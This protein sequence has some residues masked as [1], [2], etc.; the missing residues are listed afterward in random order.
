MA[1]LYFQVAYDAM[2]TYFHKTLFSFLSGL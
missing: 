1:G 2:Q